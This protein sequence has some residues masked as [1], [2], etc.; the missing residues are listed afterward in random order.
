MQEKFQVTVQIPGAVADVENRVVLP[1]VFS[2]V[3]SVVKGCRTL[4][5]DP[6]VRPFEKG[7]GNDL[8][9][10]VGGNPGVEDGVIN[11]CDDPEGNLP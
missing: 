1:A 8:P 3:Q 4:K 7:V 9:L 2:P 5:G 6:P 10:H 11:V